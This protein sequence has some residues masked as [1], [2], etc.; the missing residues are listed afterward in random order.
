MRWAPQASPWATGPRSGPPTRSVRSAGSSEGPSVCL[1]YW[2]QTWECGGAAGRNASHGLPGL[3]TIISGKSGVQPFVNHANSLQ[4]N[5][6]CG[7]GAGSMP[8]VYTA[9]T[10]PPGTR[11]SCPN[12]E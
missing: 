5:T 2:A 10:L 12:T 8:S 9:Q 4:S 6:R 7:S 11:G 3:M 1:A